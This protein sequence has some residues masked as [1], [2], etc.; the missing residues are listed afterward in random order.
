MFIWSE[1][2]YSNHLVENFFMLA[3]VAELVRACDC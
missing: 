3:R 1:S 2:Q